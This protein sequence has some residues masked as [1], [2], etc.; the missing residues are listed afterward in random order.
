MCG[1]WFQL[2]FNK[3]NEYGYLSSIVTNEDIYKSFSKIQHRGPDRSKLLQLNL[4][5]DRVTLHLGFH[6]LSI[7]DN[8]T[9]GDQPFL[10]KLDNGKRLIYTLTNGEIYNFK[11]LREKYGVITQSNSDCE[12]IGHLY[13]QIGLSYVKELIGEFATII[14]DINDNNIKIH[15]I[16][17]PFG[18]RPLFLS[19]SLDNLIMIA[20]SE[21]K[22]IQ[23]IL[24]NYSP[25]ELNIW[26][27]DPGTI[28]S[29][30]IDNNGG[31]LFTTYDSQ[32]YYDNSYKYDTY[33]INETECL[34]MIKKMLKKS[35][36]SMIEADRPLGALLSGGLDSSL[37]CSIASSYLKKRGKRLDTFSIGLNSGSTDKEYAL[38]VSKH[39]GTN[40]THVEFSQED[41]INAVKH[42]IYIIETFDIT[43]I[44][45][46]VGQYLISK[47]ISENTDIKVLLVGD[48]S[49]ELTGGYMYFHNCPDPKSF[50]EEC[51]KLLNTI[52]MYDVLRADRG[53]ASNGLE[54]RVPFLNHNF[55][56]SYMS[57]D[58]NLRMVRN[59]TEKYLLRKAFDTNDDKYLPKKVLWR[60]KEAF[61]DGVSNLEKSWFQILQESFVNININTN[62]NIKKTTLVKPHTTEAIV[63]KKWFDEFYN[64]DIDNNILPQ[65]WMPNW[66]NTIDPSARTLEIYHNNK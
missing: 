7:M 43:T 27:C 5:D 26:H 63:Y 1:I 20:A 19:E 21:I 23:D 62:I 42:V 32:R 49:D 13:N 54:A 25:N 41:F 53:I 35:V 61:S 9:L 33:M 52:H 66:S 56:Q 8:S 46:S 31:K 51:K 16:R 47:Y 34:I 38:E 40:H 6:R 22:S 30:I 4:L 3:I 60:K 57:I 48:G 55:V 65:Y 14:I 10:L 44:R 15:Y 50:H 37:V 45:A 36:I 18:V 11:E 24:N 28:Y 2:M 58:P 59:N 12:I 64:V 39:C 17:D 29:V